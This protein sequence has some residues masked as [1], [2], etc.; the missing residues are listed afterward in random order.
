MLSDLN[1]ASSKRARQIHEANG[2]SDPQMTKCHQT[3]QLL[4]HNLQNQ[5]M[6]DGGAGENLN[7]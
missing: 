5:Q 6:D 7:G 4:K 2:A 3:S 1:A